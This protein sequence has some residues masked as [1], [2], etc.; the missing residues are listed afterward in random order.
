MTTADFKARIK[1]NRW[2]FTQEESVSCPPTN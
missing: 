2:P 1:K